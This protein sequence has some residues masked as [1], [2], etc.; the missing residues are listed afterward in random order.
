MKDF[1]PADILDAAKQTYL[2]EIQLDSDPEAALEKA[3]QAGLT[4]HARQ[5][6]VETAELAERLAV[7][8][9]AS[10]GD[11]LT[12][13]GEYLATDGPAALLWLS[14]QLREKIPPEGETHAYTP[15]DDDLVEV[16]IPGTV[17]KQPGSGE[18][19]WSLISDDGMR[20]YAF[21]QAID[22]DLRVRVIVRSE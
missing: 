22:T 5:V 6:V 13:E 11:D 14:R 12:E 18:G 17:M 4:A 7:E 3:L 15:H 20:E 16:T 10:G 21:S 8:L 19:D 9:D 1:V 2:L